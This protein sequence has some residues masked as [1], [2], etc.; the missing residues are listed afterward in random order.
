MNKTQSPMTNAL[1]NALEQHNN[2]LSYNGGIIAYRDE[3]KVM[4]NGKEIIIE[5][6]NIYF[7]DT[8]G[9]KYALENCTYGC[10]KNAINMV[11]DAFELVKKTVRIELTAHV[12]VE[13]MYDD[14]MAIQRAIEQVAKNPQAYLGMGDI[15]SVEAEETPD[16]DT[17]T[18]ENYLERY[19]YQVEAIRGHKELHID[20]FVY[21][22]E[23]HYDLVQACGCYIPV[24]DLEGKTPDEI[25]DLIDN[26][27]SES[28][29]YQ[30][31]ITENEIMAYYSPDRNKPLGFIHV[32]EDTPC[33]FYLA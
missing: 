6:G 30:G 14:N 3:Q 27:F 9:E 7:V 19:T 22:N 20:G 10:V 31:E 26:A 16:P 11:T 12:S 33:G 2:R 29:Q 18:I 1:V 21:W 32:T 24:S 5:N 17:A 8:T 13:K 28:N 15:I 23:D 25:Y 4:V